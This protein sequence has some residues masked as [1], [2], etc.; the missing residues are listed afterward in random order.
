MSKLKQQL[1]QEWAKCGDR[2]GGEMG[3]ICK[4]LAEEKDTGWEMRRLAER[5]EKRGHV[6][7]SMILLS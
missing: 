1:S 7:E 5:E 2:V 6:Y 3:N 4:G